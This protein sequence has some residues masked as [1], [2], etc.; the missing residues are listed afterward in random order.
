[1]DTTKTNHEK[2]F[3]EKHAGLIIGVPWIIILIIGITLCSPLPSS[4]LYT[5]I[6]GFVIVGFWILITIGLMVKS[7]RLNSKDH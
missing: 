5:R 6:L 1:M 2:K 7:A 3:L 4:K